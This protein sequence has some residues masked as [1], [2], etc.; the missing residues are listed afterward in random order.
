MEVCRL[1]SPHLMSYVK[2]VSLAT[3]PWE[4]LE[5]VGPTPC[6]GTVRHL[7]A[8]RSPREQLDIREVDPCPWGG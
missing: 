2:F 6:P 7:E 8:P 5:Y 3:G 1:R 4:Q